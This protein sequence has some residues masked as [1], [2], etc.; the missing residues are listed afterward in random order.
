MCSSDPAP[1]PA[2]PPPVDTGLSTEQLECEICELSAHM[3][4]GMCRWLLLVAEFDRRQAWA[5]TGMYSCAQWLSWRCS[6]GLRAAHEHVRVANRLHELRLVTE[7]F[8]QGRL[9][10]SKVRAIT[11][12]A[13]H[14]NEDYLVMLGEY[15]SGAQLEK[16]VSGYRGALAATIDSEQRAHEQR[17]LWAFDQSDGSV[18]IHA[19][20]PPEGAAVLMAA[21]DRA[22]REARGRTDRPTNGLSMPHRRSRSVPRNTRR[23]TPCGGGHALVTLARA[24]LD[25]ELVVHVDAQTLTGDQVIDRS[26]TAGGSSLAP[27]TVRRLGCD[28]GLVRIL[29]RDGRPLSVS[30]KRRTVPPV[31]KRALRERDQRCRFPGCHHDRYLHAHHIHHWARGGPTS[32]D[33]LVHLCTFHHRLVHE[34]GF[35]V[36]RAGGPDELRFVRPDGC[37][38][39][40]AP[41]PVRP[42]GPGICDQNRAKGIKIDADTAQGIEAGLKF[43]YGMA[44]DGL[45]NREIG[46]SSGGENGVSVHRDL[47]GQSLTTAL[48]PSSR[49]A[50]SSAATAT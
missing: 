46:L 15:A 16:I 44:I 5:T 10:Y 12:V 42:R 24:Q 36:E 39:E 7:A 17:Y 35:A 48:R 29:E 9:S 40:E 8:S 2:P 32:L 3:A 6:I 4:V 27:E 19:K 41:R 21:I 18:I 33:N 20:I 38:V 28:A 31:L 47:H 30:H 13:T 11:R 22:E 34:G 49:P 14:E 50:A 45:L 25:V 43:D 23:R 1:S 37:V 26:A